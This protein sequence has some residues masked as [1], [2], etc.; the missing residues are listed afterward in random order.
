ML[1]KAR[2]ARSLAAECDA[3]NGLSGLA[4]LRRAPEMVTRVREGLAAAEREGSPHRLSEARARAAQVLVV[5]GRL[6][7][8]AR[9]LDDVIASARASGATSALRTG[10]WYRGFVHYWQSEY[11]IAEV[12]GTEGFLIAEEAGDAFEALAA[13]MFAALS[14]ANLG[15]LSEALTDFQQAL[16]LAERNRDSFW[17][18][19]LMSHLGWVR[20]ELQAPER[21]REFD[22]RALEM[23]RKN[24]NPW[25]PEAEALINLCV[26][27]VRAGHPDRAAELLSRLEADARQGSWMRWMNELRLEAAASEHWAARGD[28]GA[29]AARATRLLEIARSLGARTYCCAAERVRL[30]AALHSGAGVEAAAGRLAAAL[31]EFETFPAPLEAWKSARVLGDALERLGRGPEA[32]RAFDTAARAVRTIAKGTQ[33]EELRSGFLAS[34]AVRE[35]LERASA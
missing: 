34:P 8:A 26:D 9:A 6:E 11:Q 1:E 12:L 30:A 10:L 27:D 4:F 14:R 15:R 2:A 13:R 33:D 31:A 28:F 19:R 32:R 7:E 3:L 35:V 17:G 22:T 5:E 20:R 21:A 16:E 25:T 29:A 18:P 24:P 23:A